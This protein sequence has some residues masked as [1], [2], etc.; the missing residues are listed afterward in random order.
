MDT[1][2][3]IQ[4][5]VRGIKMRQAD[6]LQ[7]LYRQYGGALNG[8]IARMIPSEELSQEVLQDCFMRIWDKI[9]QYDESKA[10][11]FTWMAQIARN[12]AKDKLKSK[13]FSYNNK[14]DS[15]EGVVSKENQ[16]HISEE[17]R[18]DD[19]GV[20]NLKGYL[21]S[22]ERLI[23]E[24]LYFKGYTHQELSE[25]MDIPLGTVKTRL[26]M[27]ITNLRKALAIKE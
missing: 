4:E 12:L 6:A 20:S 8:I 24:Y 13:E 5:I 18:V 16:L 10:R 23:I 17:M 2:K 9:D 1:D 11:F 15:L 27:A 26:R 25:E 7:V 14:T 22:E 19:I 3:D 21:R